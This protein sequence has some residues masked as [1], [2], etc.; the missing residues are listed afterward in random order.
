M[1]IG[2][3]LYQRDTKME[4]MLTR[5]EW[6]VGKEGLER[7]QSKTVLLFGV[8]GVGGYALEAL[9]RSGVG[10]IVIVDGDAVSISNL[11]RQIIG[12][13]HTIGKRKVA[14]AKERAHSIRPNVIIE[15]HDMVYTGET[16]PTFIADVQPDYVIDA[17][18]MVS[19]KL[20]I[21]E[22]CFYLGIPCI[23]SMGT[24]NKMYP[25]QL[26][27][28]DIYKTH[29]CPL[30]KVMRKE[31]KK[32]RVKKQVVVFSTEEPLQPNRDDDSRS[33]GSISFVP[34]VAGLMLAGYVIRKFLE[35][36]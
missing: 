20:A 32:R 6:L 2:Q 10:R 4:H 25:E 11:N 14:V 28:A 23:S 3:K 7:L 16:Y 1:V 17:I 26:S 34:P 5:L 35:V 29:T 30:A 19:A 33:P 8:G 22:Q 9:V 12:T 21:I 15:A 27:I 18:D 13:V 24:G 36:K 31:L